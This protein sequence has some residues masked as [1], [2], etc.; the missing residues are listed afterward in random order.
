[1]ITGGNY[2]KLSAGM[3]TIRQRVPNMIITRCSSHAPPLRPLLVLPV[4]HARPYVS[5]CSVPQDHVIRDHANPMRSVPRGHANPMR[6][7][8]RGRANPMRSVPRGHAR[9]VYHV[10]RDHARLYY[11]DQELVVFQCDHAHLAGPFQRVS[12]FPFY[13]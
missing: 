6:S 12:K 8:P 13:H 1:M 4:G 5:H 9:P 11:A 3:M 10:L 2:L 7:V